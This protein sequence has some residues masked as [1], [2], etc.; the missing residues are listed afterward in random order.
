MLI[1]CASAQANQQ[2]F[3]P[4]KNSRISLCQNFK[5]LA[6]LCCYTDWFVSDLVG[7]TEDRFVSDLVGNPEDR[8]L[9]NEV[10]IM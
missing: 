5:L 8:F 2:L 1:R 9:H 7:N 3:W 4:P 6:G 10:H